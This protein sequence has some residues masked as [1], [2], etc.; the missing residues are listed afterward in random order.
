MLMEVGVA[1]LVSDK[2]SC[3]YSKLLVK[4]WLAFRRNS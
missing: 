3:K 2:G 1:T 4:I